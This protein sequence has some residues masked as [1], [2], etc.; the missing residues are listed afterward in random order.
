L[1]DDGRL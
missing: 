1:T